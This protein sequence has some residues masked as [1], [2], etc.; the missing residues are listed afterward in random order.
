MLEW[1]QLDDE[2]PER[3][4]QFKSDTSY[5]FW[6]IALAGT[7]IVLRYGKIGNN[8]TEHVVPHDNLSEAKQDYL[9]RLNQKIKQRYVEVI[10]K[11]PKETTTEEFREQL[12]DHDPFLNAILESPDEVGPY[13]IYADWLLEHGDPLGEFIQVQ[14]ALENPHLEMWEEPALK[15]TEGDLISAHGRTWLG[16]LKTLLFEWSRDRHEQCFKFFRGL[17]SEIRIPVFAPSVGETITNSPLCRMLRRINIDQIR[18]FRRRDA[19]AITSEPD[20]SEQRL[21]TLAGAPFHNLRELS[22]GG[23][24]FPGF[25]LD[26]RDLADV[27][28]SMPRLEQLSLQHVDVDLHALAKTEMPSLTTLTIT[29]ESP[30]SSIER[31]AGARWMKQLTQLNIDGPVNTKDVQ[32]LLSHDSLSGLNLMV[33]SDDN[34]ITSTGWEALK[35]AGVSCLMSDAPFLDV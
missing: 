3:R 31:L 11:P 5:K 18:S 7:D 21:H 12:S 13:Q 23:R 24:S 27:V 14:I 19:R 16:D 8:G 22:L 28:P 29:R 35:D 6:T 15:K 9:K 33:V 17:L 30:S 20:E 34:R 1:E 4:F 25:L 32:Q 10:R 26:A 2:I